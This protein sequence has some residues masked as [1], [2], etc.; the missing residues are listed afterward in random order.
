MIISINAIKFLILLNHNLKS[1]LEGL[2]HIIKIRI[3]QFGHVSSY[4]LVVMTK[5]EVQTLRHG[6]YLIHWKNGGKSLAAIGSKYNGDRWICCTNWTSAADKG[7]DTYN[8]EIWETID[9]VG[10]I[11][12]DKEN[13][14]QEIWDI[15]DKI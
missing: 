2:H 12:A 15:I 13:Y 1:S 11:A 7:T 14:N 9:K 8:Q 10:V 5:D 6:L 3:Y 4:P